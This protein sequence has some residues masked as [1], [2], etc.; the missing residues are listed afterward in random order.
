[1]VETRNLSRLAA[2][3]VAIAPVVAL[4]AASCGTSGNVAD[5]EGGADSA[6]L[7]SPT[8][9]G[10]RID[11]AVGEGGDGGRQTLGLLR[12]RRTLPTGASWPPPS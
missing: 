7:D 6:A 1:M 11:G 12:M 5:G 10:P 9:D 4:F 3:L 8:I 2:G